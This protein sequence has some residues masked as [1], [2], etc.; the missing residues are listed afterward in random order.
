VQC[1]VL[2]VSDVVVLVP[3]LGLGPDA[4]DALAALLRDAGFQIVGYDPRPAFETGVRR[5]KDFSLHDLATDTAAVIEHHQS[6]AHLIG[7]AFGN[8]VAR[9][10][11]ADRPDIVRS[12]TLLAAGG[13]VAPDPAVGSALRSAEPGERNRVLFA[14]GNKPVDFGGSFSAATAAAQAAAM[15]ATPL[16]DRWLGGTA[17]MLV[18]QGLDDRV[19]VPDNGRQLIADIGERGQLVEIANAGHALLVEQPEAIAQALI[20]FLRSH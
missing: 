8:R 12:L 19:A 9:C 20:P 18:I 4:F 2:E 13:Q 17:A 10:V 1:E 16:A 3:G 11:A 14:P 5:A 6:P 7:W 15:D